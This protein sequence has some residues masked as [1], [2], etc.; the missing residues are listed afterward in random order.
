MNTHDM[1]ASINR[2]YRNQKFK[3]ALKGIGQFL[4]V[5][6]VFVLLFLGVNSLLDII[7]SHKIGWVRTS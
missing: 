6:I 5:A 4:I 1:Q 2:I 3:N 7:F